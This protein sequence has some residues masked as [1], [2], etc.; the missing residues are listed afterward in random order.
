[1]TVTIAD[2]LASY[3]DH[4]PLEE[5]FTIPA[6]WYFDPRIGDLE[7]DRVFGGNWIAVGRSDQ[8]EKAG[9]F[10]TFNLAGEPLVAVRGRDHRV[11]SFFNVCRHRAARPFR[12]CFFRHRA[13]P[14]AR[15][16]TASNPST[17]RGLGGDLPIQEVG[18]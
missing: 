15:R 1:M 18:T 3:N 10:F 7:R 4:A 17:I 12:G 6:P 9:Q 13:S 14:I 2:V 16:E 5:A 8:V 11:Q